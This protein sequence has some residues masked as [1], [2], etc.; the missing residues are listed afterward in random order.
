MRA[1]AA[2]LSLHPSDHELLALATAH[3]HS[4]HTLAHQAACHGGGC[5]HA[6]RGNV[7]RSAT[8][9]ATASHGGAT[10]TVTPRMIS[11]PTSLAHLPRPPLSRSHHRHRP[12]F[13]RRTEPDG[14]ARSD[15]AAP[16]ALAAARAG[17]DRKAVDVRAL[18]VNHLTSATSFFVNMNGRSK[19][20][21]AAIVKNVED[22]MAAQFGR[23]AH[24]QGKAVSAEYVDLTELD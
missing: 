11:V 5:A 2:A 4:R 7:T 6:R 12:R 18:R 14:E 16:L 15:P 10:R 20:Q 8:R 23:T 24:R 21:I 22:E 1:A 3:A 13:R 19:A 17:D 9:G